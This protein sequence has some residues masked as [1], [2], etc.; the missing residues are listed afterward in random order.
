VSEEL[1]ELLNKAGET[2]PAADGLRHYLDALE[3]AARDL[4]LEQPSIA[5]M[6][7]MR[8]KGLTR[9]AA[10]LMGIEA[11]MI[12]A[13]RAPDQEE[14]RRMLYVA[15]TRARLHLYLTMATT[16]TGPTAFA[17][18]GQAGSSRRRSPFFSGAGLQPVNGT[19]YLRSIGA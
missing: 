1:A 19:Q 8:S 5:I 4:A 6:S 2:I 13:P 18:G 7:M 3:P 17:G 10:I 9:P 15:M 14:A 16:H 11:D 12:P